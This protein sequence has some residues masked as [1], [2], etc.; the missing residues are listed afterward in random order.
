[1]PRSRRTF[2]VYARAC[3]ALLLVAAVL[4]GMAG[5]EPSS[6]S[7]NV[8]VWARPLQHQDSAHIKASIQLDE[9]TPVEEV[10]TIPCEIRAS[11]ALEQPWARLYVF[12]EQGN[13]LFE[14]RAGLDAVQGASQPVFA[15]PVE[16]LSDG[17]YR[18]RLEVFH[19]LNQPLAWREVDL[20]KRSY[21]VLFQRLEHVLTL[22]RPVQESIQEAPPARVPVYASIR[23]A[24]AADA[25]RQAEAALQGGDWPLA[26]ALGEFAAMSCD[27]ARALLTFAP[28]TPELALPGPAPSGTSLKIRNGAFYTPASDPVFLFGFRD[29]AIDPRILALLERYGLNFAAID[30]SPAELLLEGATNLDT[31]ARVDTYLENADARGI[32]VTVGLAADIAPAWLSPG[33]TTMHPESS[34]GRSVHGPR[35]ARALSQRH[36]D[37]MAALLQR[38]PSVNGVS[39][40][41]APAF[42]WETEEV[43]QG[44]QE[45]VSLKYKG[46]RRAVNRAWRTRLRA[47]DEI[48]ILWDYPQPSYQYDWQTW[49]QELVSDY[50]TWLADYA[51]RH[52]RGLPAQ[53]TLPDTAIQTGE[54]RTGIDRQALVQLTEVTACA[55]SCISAAPADS[56]YAMP[57]TRPGLSYRLLRS[58]APAN[59]LVALD[60]RF[61]LSQIPAGARASQC[62]HA[63][64]WDAAIAGVNGFAARP[65][66][67]E[68][69]PGGLEGFATACADLNRL[70]EIV[71]AFQRAHAPI[72]VL[73]STPSKIYLDGETFL[74][75]VQRVYEGSAFF[76]FPIRFVTEEACISGGLAEVSVLVMPEVPALADETFQAINAY[77]KA[78]G[79]IIRSGRPA[80]YTPAGVSRH[81][82]IAQT[83][84]TIF[85]RGSDTPTVYLHALD[86]AYVF[87]VLPPIPRTI[88]RYGY[89]L[90]GVQSRY[91]ELDGQEYLY[92]VNL[93]REP[94]RVN[95][96][97]GPRKG[98]DL[99]RG[100]GIQFPTELEPLEPVLVHLAP[101]TPDA[102]AQ[103]VAPVLAGSQGEADQG[104]AGPITLSPVAP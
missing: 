28:L 31:V 88:N 49:H 39:L 97:G 18:A 80:P 44:F 98:R 90:E 83:S 101:L 32:G 82:V 77:A 50:F 2:F 34:A 92:V 51:G 75:S 52:L 9:V 96:Y 78:G 30:V 38:H 71:T 13:A 87:G 95:L 11:T 22:L 27:S 104:E 70:G 79:A 54:A 81:D 60:L 86:A 63:A 23:A 7:S 47:L 45:A 94:V 21:A 103:G 67:F 5:A 12:D 91:V 6:A 19:A 66:E 61:D 64:V 72:A 1:M 69:N 84:R 46:D 53:I 25:L 35:E 14:G 3:S 15:W 26:T 55:A 43:R 102:A 93:R 76:G 8:R 62:V 56:M 40:A 4:T 68:Q 41:S 58:L 73:W 10:L 100:R 57:L 74:E 17:V 33:Q 48:Q 20:E 24:I 85:V 42:H 36:L 99:V 37:A 59:P 89:P 29:P 16:D 65:A